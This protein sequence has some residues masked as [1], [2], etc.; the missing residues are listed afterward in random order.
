M[1]TRDLKDYY[2]LYR[3][4]SLGSLSRDYVLDT[5]SLELTDL[6]IYELFAFYKILDDIRHD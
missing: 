2:N 3:L 4:Y 5:V 6:N 1:A